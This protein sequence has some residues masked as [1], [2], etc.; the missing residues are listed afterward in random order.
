MPLFADTSHDQ[1][2]ELT[3]LDEGDSMDPDDKIHGIEIPDGFRIQASTL[4]ALDVRRFKHVF[5]VELFYTIVVKKSD[6]FSANVNEWYVPATF[7]TLFD[8][9]HSC[10]LSLNI[11]QRQSDSSRR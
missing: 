5:F 11:Y 7:F 10:T 8:K 9:R 4:A 6:A 2:D 1:N 3:L